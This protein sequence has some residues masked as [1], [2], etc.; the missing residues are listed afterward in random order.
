[1]NLLTFDAFLCRRNF[2][3]RT[4]EELRRIGFDVLTAYEDEKANQAIDDETVLNRA[5]ELDRVIL[6]LNRRDFINLHKA[7]PNHSG[8]IV[9]TEDFDRVGQAA[10]I[11]EKVSDSEDLKGILLR[12]YRPSI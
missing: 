9:C 5:A 3:L 6:T 4:V 2:P 12:V 11:T 10:R 7:N 1:M 8:I